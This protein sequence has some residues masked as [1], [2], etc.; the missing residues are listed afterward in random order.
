MTNDPIIDEIRK[1]RK[2]TEA[3]FGNNADEYFNYLQHI[4][5]KHKN[6][7]RRKF[8]PPLTLKTKLKQRPS[9]L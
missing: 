2:E 8:K 6:M 5:K 9:E 4:Q 7:V 1:I 3:K